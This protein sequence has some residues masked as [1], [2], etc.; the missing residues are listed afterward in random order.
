MDFTVRIADKGI[1]IHSVYSK[2]YKTCQKYLID[3][4]AEP[5]MELYLNEPLI[6]E[7]FEKIRQS[8][9][10]ISSFG[11][12]ESLLAYRCIA[13][14]ML[15]YDTF[16][17][18]GAVIALG[19]AA[20][21]FAGRSGTGKTTHIQK[22]LEN[23]EGSYVVNG[24]KPLVIVKRESAFA[25]G[26]PWCGKEAMGTNA[27]VPLRSIVFMERSDENHIESVPFRAIF[28]RLLEQTYRP[29]DAGKM[30]K[31]LE[32]LMRLKDCVTFYRFRFDNYKEDAFRTS[33]DALSKWET[34]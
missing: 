29:A 28:P 21:M 18:H 26:T 34:T 8:G 25:C 9:E 4:A 7:E 27:I 30:K 10:E 1:L 3:E 23:V 33:F 15:E 19:N 20:H 11:A 12:V 16:L 31:T 2:V 22:W 6:R 5:D 13:E 24:D 17:M 14:E 32:L